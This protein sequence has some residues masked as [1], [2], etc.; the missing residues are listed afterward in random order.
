MQACV[1]RA[2]AS[3]LR[4]LMLPVVESRDSGLA[5]VLKSER[6]FLQQ[7]HAKVF[8]AVMDKGGFSGNVIDFPAQRYSSFSK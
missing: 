7:L 3:L 5:R 2:S 8:G 1:Y 4:S 6:A